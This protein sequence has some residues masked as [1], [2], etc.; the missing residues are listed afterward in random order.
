MLFECNLNPTHWGSRKLSYFY[1]LPT[2]TTILQIY[3]KH[4]CYNQH[5]ANYNTNSHWS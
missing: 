5:H 4:L 1:T 3:T 2:T